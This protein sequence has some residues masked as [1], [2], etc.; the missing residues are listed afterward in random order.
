MQEELDDFFGNFLKVSFT[1]TLPSIFD[2]ARDLT[3][4]S[5]IFCC[6]RPPKLFHLHL[7]LLGCLH[8]SQLD[9]I[10]YATG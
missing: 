10:F 6:K 2:V 4:A 8:L 9:H 5:H 7:I 3:F 1:V